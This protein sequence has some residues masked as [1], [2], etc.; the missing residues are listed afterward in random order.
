VSLAGTFKTAGPSGDEGA[1]KTGEVNPITKNHEFYVESLEELNSK[2]RALDSK[3]GLINV[4]LANRQIP[5]EDFSREKLAELVARSKEVLEDDTRATLEDKNTVE[6][7]R[8]LEESIN[9]RQKTYRLKRQFMENIRKMKQ[10]QEAE[11]SKLFDRLN[12]V[13]DE[14]LVSERVLNN[15]QVA[16]KQNTEEIAHVQSRM[17]FVNED[18]HKLEVEAHRLEEELQAVKNKQGQQS[19][20]QSSLARKI[21]E[22]KAQLEIKVRE[23]QETQARLV[24]EQMSVFENKQKLEYVENLAV[25]LAKEFQVLLKTKTKRESELATK[26]QALRDTLHTKSRTDE[27][28]ERIRGTLATIDG[29]DFSKSCFCDLKEDAK[30]AYFEIV[31]KSDQLLNQKQPYPF[32]EQLVTDFL[33]E[34]DVG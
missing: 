20:D 14:Y 12:Q 8:M 10:G 7:L 17:Q 24:G 32:Y 29:T 13:E 15:L 34:K 23:A 11:L 27:E 25:E 33:A 28:L 21:G 5:D 1:V 16:I 3:F 6:L 31:Y 9:E 19:T 26:V 4:V 18:W 30:N 2:L 22:Y